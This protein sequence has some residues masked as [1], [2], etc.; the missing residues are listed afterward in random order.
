SFYLA[1][2]LAYGAA[3]AAQDFWLEQVVKRGWTERG[4]PSV[5]NPKLSLGWAVIVAAAVAIDRLWFSRA[6]RTARRRSPSF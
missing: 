6:R 2:M 4:I 1:L 3:N 5:L